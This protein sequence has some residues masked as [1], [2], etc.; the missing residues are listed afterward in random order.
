MLRGRGLGS[1]IGAAGGAL[2]VLVNAAELPGSTTLRVAGV[3]LF[4]AAVVVA[5]R[6]PD[7][8]SR[9]P[10][11]RAL[12][13]YG[14]C[15]AGEVLAIPV[16]AAILRALDR[17]ELVRVWVVLVLGV[18]FVPFAKAFGEPI[19]RAL[20]VVL[21]LIALAGGI[22]TIAILGGSEPPPSVSGLPRSSVAT[23]HTSEP[24][25]HTDAPA[26]SAVT[27]G[28]VLLAFSIGGAAGSPHG[29]RAA[30]L[31]APGA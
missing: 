30:D 28:F 26:W 14:W 17:P 20:G 13:I 2:F 31:R 5:L 10:P 12:K 29:R 24:A 19:F 7:D 3:V 15:V 16:G 9:P 21:I 27:A 18:H 1:L 4:A 23:L 6:A 8:G 22:V 25:E 11:P